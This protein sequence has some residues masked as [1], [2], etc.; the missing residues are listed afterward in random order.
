MT[1]RLVV[2]PQAEA[3]LL[4]ARD[5]FE[6]QEAGLGQE[7]ALEVDLTISRIIERP[8][9]FPQVHGPK[10]RAIVH[11]FPYGVFFRIVEGTVVILGIVHARRN[12]QRWQQRQ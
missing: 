10:R 3:E 5:W 7:F 12:P 9:I 1:F 11:R 2:R 8:E 6:G 4:E